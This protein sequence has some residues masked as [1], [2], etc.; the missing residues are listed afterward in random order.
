MAIVTR[1]L[2]ETVMRAGSG[3]G[4][5]GGE[6]ARRHE[7]GV[8]QQVDR[9][10]LVGIEDHGGAGLVPDEIAHHAVVARVGLANLAH[11]TVDRERRFGNAGLEVVDVLGAGGN[12]AKV[13]RMCHGC[14]LRTGCDTTRFA[15]V[16]VTRRAALK[17]GSGGALALVIGGVAGWADRRDDPEAVTADLGTTTTTTTTSTTTTTT[18]A[19]V[20]IPELPAAVDPAIIALGRRV[21]AETGEDDLPT[22][23]R[24]LPGASDDPLVDAA[25]VVRDD[26]A[27]RRTVIVDGWVL[28]VSEA[29]A[30]AVIA[31][32]CDADAC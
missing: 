31:L 32:L 12:E 22:L 4:R 11:R 21:I 3:H 16:P 30:A 2:W 7:A 5:A 26:F 13:G 27:Q 24:A 9:P 10:L 17:L 28:A 8:G 20:R 29:R 6:P 15:V 19:P 25:A 23:L 18:A 14:T 1:Q